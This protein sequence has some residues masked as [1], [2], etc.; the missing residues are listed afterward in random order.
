MECFTVENHVVGEAKKEKGEKRSAKQLGPHSRDSGQG[1]ETK[2]GQA[3]GSQKKQCTDHAADAKRKDPPDQVE[4]CVGQT[5]EQVGRGKVGKSGP[6]RAR[7]IEGRDHALFCRA[8]ERE[9]SLSAACII[10]D[11]LH[12]FI[13]K[14]RR[15]HADGL[16]R[17]KQGQ[18]EE[19]FEDGD[20]PLP[21]DLVL[22][23]Q[24]RDLKEK[25]RTY[26]G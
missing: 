18:H 24:T 16:V 20:F 10:G 13:R 15:H 17:G 14:V 21:L 5:L 23:K 1:L 8:H 3:V 11:H 4:Q 12:G 7:G 6:D 22:Q 25:H 26:E 2:K 19:Q 9:E